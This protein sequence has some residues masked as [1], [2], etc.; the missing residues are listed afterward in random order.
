MVRAV[1]KFVWHLVRGHKF[2]RFTANIKMPLHLVK[3]F[4]PSKSGQSAD[5]P[6]RL[7]HCIGLLHAAVKPVE[8]RVS[9]QIICQCIAE[10]SCSWL[11]LS[12]WKLAV[13]TV[14]M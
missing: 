1:G 12:F 2:V 13:V 6:F 14:S 3:A 9:A 4:G 7:C 5:A 10:L 11:L 8:L